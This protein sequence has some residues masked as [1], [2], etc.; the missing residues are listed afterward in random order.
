MF[1]S[2]NGPEDYRIRNAANAGVGSTGP[3]RGRKRS[4][5]EGGIRTFGLVRWPGKVPAGRV[6]ETSVMAA[7]EALREAG[8]EV[9]GVAVIVDRGAGDAVREAGLDYRAAYSLADLGLA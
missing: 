2:D 9:V 8:A 7:V 5:Y 3:L 1:S 6:D 4:M